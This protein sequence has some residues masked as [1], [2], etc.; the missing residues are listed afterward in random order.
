MT[1]R[2]RHLVPALLTIAIA[3]PAQ[4][5]AA[6]TRAERAAL[7]E[8]QAR[9]ESIHD[10]QHLAALLAEPDSAARGKT[11]HLLGMLR[12]GFTRYRLGQLTHNRR[13][14]DDALEDF[15]SVI[16]QRYTWPVAWYGL[17]LTKV[18]MAREQLV[19]YEA[20]HQQPG[21]SYADE[22][23]EA[24]NRALEYDEDYAAP[25]VAL[26]TL[27][28]DAGTFLARDTGLV[29]LKQAR[30]RFSSGD[31]AGGALAYRGAATR[32]SSRLVREQLRADLAWVADSAE[33]RSFDGTHATKLAPWLD[34][35]WERRDVRELRRPGE[36]LAE[37]Y[38]RLAYAEE[39]FA[40]LGS[41]RPSLHFER[42]PEG[43]RTL[44]DRAVIYIRH[45][46]PQDRAGFN[47][48]FGTA[49]NL[50]PQASGIP[51]SRSMPGRRSVRERP[52]NRLSPVP[53]NLSWKY[54]R[55]EGNLIFHF[56][57]H[58]GHDYRLIESLLDVFSLDTVIKLQMGRI[59]S[60]G[61]VASAWEEA[62]YA[63]ALVA[64]RS[65]LDP[66]YA[67][68]A[69]R[70]TIQGSGNLRSERAA[71]QESLEIGLNT[72][73]Y[74]EAYP[75]A[76]EPVIQAYGIARG[77]EGRVLVVVGVPTERSQARSLALKTV[78]SDLGDRRL[79][80]VDTALNL[81]SPAKG[82][83][84]GLIELPVEPGMRRVRVV[85]VDTALMAAGGVTIDQVAVPTAGRELTLSDLV[86]G[87]EDGL[88]WNGPDGRVWLDADGELAPG[89]TAHLYYQVSGLRTGTTYRTRI[90]L[91]RPSARRPIRR[92]ASE[93][94]LLA[95]SETQAE[96]RELSLAGLLAGEYVLQL[97][98]TGPGGQ[99]SRDRSIR[100]R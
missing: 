75:E 9:V 28:R 99:I 12:R 50:A 22:A 89:R 11:V 93:F 4:S 44:D 14:Y 92:I 26:A 46:P 84:G 33:L 94:D 79:T 32:G 65:E 71:G 3:Q 29:L 82:I 91:R 36:R 49:E 13:Y 58:S 60:V 47:S 7:S 53:P 30:E 86:L 41:P 80:Q 23:R 100:L 20:I 90:E 31:T 54:E 59:D 45:G 95:R 85:A 98:L 73:S 21:Y 55:P 24:L 52:D 78:V 40:R 72:D 2:V 18:S 88:S 51:E 68:L 48:P 17:G 15:W 25:E 66:V 63:K 16:E 74:R 10:P 19:P 37:H 8:W 57:A 39:H 27:E 69:E 5:I 38:R 77:S 6:Q 97:T 96:R 62:R 81:V 87:Q 64:S 43:D 76:L 67:R 61:D 83:R 1:L 56:V 42:S 34:A 70:I 35:F